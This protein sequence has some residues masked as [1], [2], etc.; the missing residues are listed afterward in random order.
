MA[1]R[2]ETFFDVKG[3]V[4]KTLRW[5]CLPELPVRLFNLNSIL[6]INNLVKSILKVD[7]AMQEGDQGKYERVCVWKLI[8]LEIDKQ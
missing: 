4:T 1:E 5:I 8:L 6:R 2:W 7:L 3:T